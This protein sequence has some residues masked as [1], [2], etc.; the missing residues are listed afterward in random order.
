MRKIRDPLEGG[1]SCAR[2]LLCVAYFSNSPIDQTW[3]VISRFCVQN[4]S[5]SG[6]AFGMSPE[7]AVDAMV[8]SAGGGDETP[9]RS[10]RRGSAGWPVWA[11]E[12][13]A[14]RAGWG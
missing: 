13:S 3:L 6:A 9:G 14:Y 1:F 8:W 2:I 5:F 4:G 10:D 11:E 12:R 7:E